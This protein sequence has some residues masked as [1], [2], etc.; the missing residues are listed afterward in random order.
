MNDNNI[1]RLTDITKRFAGVCALDK[2]SFSIKRGEIHALMGENGAG[3]ST[4]IKI[5]S[6]L[7]RADEGK[8]EFDGQQHVFDNVLEAQR[9]GISTVFQELNM[10]PYLTVSENIFLGRYPTR[11]GNID[12]NRM[13]QEAQ[14]L[15]D[16]LCV[17][18]DVHKPLN[19]YN[20][21]KQQI[22]SIIRA[23]NFNSKLIIL[24]EPTSSLDSNEVE[25]LFSIMNKLREK[26]TSIIFI[27]HRIDE[28]YRMCDSI[29]VLKDGMYIG[30]Y[31]IDKLSELE[32]LTKMIGRKDVALMRQRPYRDYRG[33]PVVLEAKNLCRAPVVNDVSFK[34]HK[35]E[36]LG[37]AGLLGAG[38]T[39]TARLLFGCDPMDSGEIYIEGERVQI[40]NPQDAT[41]NGLAFCTE[42]RREEGI[43]PDISV[44]NNMAMCTLDN[45]TSMGLISKKKREAASASYIDK[46]RIK[47]S[48]GMQ[49]V[50]NLSGGNQQK[51]ILA[52]WMA[53]NPKLIILDEPT[54]GIDVGAKEEIERLIRD[55]A[56]NGLS[57][58]YISSEMTELAN[59]CDRVLVLRD[60]CLAGELVAQEITKENIVKTIADGAKKEMNSHV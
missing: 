24:D 34:I 28:V 12:W 15:I 36:I 55:M 46:L 59:N 52:R 7:Y 2:V 18:I 10:I 8:L 43:F 60:G 5:I 23:V 19:T 45:L 22:I 4:L 29:T 33:E 32:L 48:S 16:D 44:S 57:V 56:D 58:L 21:A 37:F 26:G 50:K 31:D 13:H 54:R 39:E 41:E 25:M 40:R 9:A 42:N 27:S 30:T 49:L 47:T 51:V 53:T 1:L 17:N 11:G 14:K 38:R 20:T 35:G 3:K 6:G